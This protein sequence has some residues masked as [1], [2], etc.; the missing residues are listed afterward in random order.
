MPPCAS[1]ATASPATTATATGRNSGSTMPNAAAGNSAAVGQH[2]G[3]ERRALARPGRHVGD[4][5]EDGD[6]GRQ[7]A[8]QPDRHPGARP[9]EQLGQLDGD[10]GGGSARPPGPSPGPVTESTTSS[11]VRRSGRSSVQPGAARR[12]A[13]PRAGRVVVPDEQQVAVALLDPAV[14]H[15]CGQVGVGRPHQQPPGRRLQGG[16]APP[17]AR[18]G[19]AAAHR[20]GC[21]GSRPRRAGGWT[22]R[23]WCRRR[24][25]RAAG[26]GPPGCPAGPARWSA[27]PARAAGACAAGPPR[28]PAAALMPRE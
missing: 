25:A 13:A 14:E 27:R 3:Q 19:R 17:A 22:G 8:E 1:P 21:T 20:P 6:D 2:R 16:R 10:H 11:S 9:P 28:G 26:R 12:P 7:Q 24:S 15:R 4:R 23:P 5:Q 18:A